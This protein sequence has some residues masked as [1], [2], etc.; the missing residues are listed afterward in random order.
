MLQLPCLLG[1][2]TG[3]ECL[4]QPLEFLS[5]FGSQSSTIM[6]CLI[7]HLALASFLGSFPY[8][9]TLCFL[10]PPPQKTTYSQIFDL[11]CAS[12]ETQTKDTDKAPCEYQCTLSDILLLEGNS[13]ICGREVGSDLCAAGFSSHPAWCSRRKLNLFTLRQAGTW[14]QD[15]LLQCLHLHKHLLGQQHTKKR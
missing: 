3:Q 9:P 14:D 12:Q 11:R 8:S 1:G 5:E 10:G 15:P 13:E 7:L 2:I 4:C 6:A